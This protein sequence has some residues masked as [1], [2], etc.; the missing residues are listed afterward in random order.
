V[1]QKGLNH[2]FGN[3]T[4]VPNI[5]SEG[6]GIPEDS[7]DAG[8]MAINYGSEPMW[9]RFGLDPDAPFENVPGGFGEVENSH[10]AYSNSMTAGADPVTPVITATAGQEVRIRV[11]EPTGAG[12]GTTFNLH[13]HAWQRDPYTC[14]DS[15]K[16]GLVGKCKTGEVA[17]R[18]IGDNPIGMVLGHQESVTPSAHFDIVP[19]HGAGGV[20][21]V[22]GDYLFGDQGSFGNTSGLWG[23]LRVVPVVPE[24]P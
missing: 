16:G 17:S 9:F 7:H 11:L 13:G 15:A 19:L 22:P 24:D 6:L 23:I 1:F 18:A 21:A 20:N 8:Q 3:G 5:A 12:R 10:M 14:P 4:A 2:R